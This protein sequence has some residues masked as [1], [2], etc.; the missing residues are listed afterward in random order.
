MNMP[1]FTAEAS[2]YK[3]SGHYHT[4][5]HAI[6]SSTQ[7]SNAIYLAAKGEDFP[8]TKCTCKGCGSGGGTSPVNVLVCA[9]ARMC[10]RRDRSPMTTAKRL[11]LRDHQRLSGGTT[12]YTIGVDYYRCNN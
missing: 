5:R 1:G 4:D 3:T 9:R 10:T 12:S 7:M 6:N 2:L 11:G 8:N